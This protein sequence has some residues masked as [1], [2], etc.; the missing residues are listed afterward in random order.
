MPHK[1][2]SYEVP[3]GQKASIRISVRI[4]TSSVFFT[5]LM[6]KVMRKITTTRLRTMRNSTSRKATPAGS[7]SVVDSPKA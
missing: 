2:T 4:G 5:G 3:D 6:R 7:V 1:S